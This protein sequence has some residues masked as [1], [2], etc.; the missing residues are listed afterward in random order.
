MV[1]NLPATVGDIRDPGSIPG[2]G[3]SSGGGPGKPLQYSCWRIPWTEEAGGLQSTGSQRVR[4][5]LSDL[6]GNK[7]RPCGWALIQYDMVSL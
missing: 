1:K 5:D 7:M 2:S 4:H 3:R 6:A